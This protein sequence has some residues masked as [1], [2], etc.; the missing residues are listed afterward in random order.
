MAQ[1]LAFRFLSGMGASVGLGIGS[2]LIADLFDI[3]ERG[4]ANAVLTLASVLGP[5]LGPLLGGIITERAHWR[6]IFWTLLIACATVLAL[7]AL[8]IRETNATVIILHK[9]RRLQKELGRQDLE[10][11]Y[12]SGKQPSSPPSA[13]AVLIRGV[14]RPW[15]MLFRSPLL[16]LFSL[17]AG[18]LSGLLYI[19]LTTASSFFQQVYGWSLEASGL[20]Y[21]GLGTGSLVGLVLFAK[22][23]DLITVR[24][25]RKNNGVY[26]PE[27]RMLT[28]FLPAVFIPVTFFW[29][30]WS[31]QA[32]THWII[33][34][35]SLAP[36][37][38]SQIGI[39][40][41]IQAYW[42]DASGPY[43]ASSMACVTAVR[44]LGGSLL[45][46][47]GPRLYARLDL[48]WGNS[49]LGFVSLVMVPFTLGVY[50]YGDTLRKMYPL[51]SD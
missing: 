8:I 46:L 34:L 30:G 21:L 12:S 47:A 1:L 6:W 13:R 25:T 38:F 48:G 27:M 49:L 19:L 37:G 26:A 39:N 17:M 43:A 44:C 40:A 10:S 22:T 29:Y 32:R 33:A 5:V 3:H 7:M 15:K 45:P 42:I 41:T 16:A 36:F 35:L 18:L 20:A 31:T 50:K 23:S 11:A 4:V 9:T 2:G 51:Y 28:A 14:I 24:L